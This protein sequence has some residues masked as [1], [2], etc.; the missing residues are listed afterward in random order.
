MARLRKIVVN[1]FALFQTI[2]RPC[3]LTSLTLQSLFQQVQSLVSQLWYFG[4]HDTRDIF[5]RELISNA[6]DALE[7]LRIVALTE[8]DVWDGASPLNVTIK[9]QPNP[10]G[11]GGKIIITGKYSFRLS[12]PR[13]HGVYQTRASG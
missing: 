10:G 12:Y 7:K 9:V 5:L 3:M 11:H 4:S 2:R 1:R 13:T 8:K 6:N